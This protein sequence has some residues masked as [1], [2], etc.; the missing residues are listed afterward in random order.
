MP[1]NSGTIYQIRWKEICPWLI[2]TSAWR[3]SFFLTVLFLSWLGV[4]L[5]QWGW[6]SLDGVLPLD[7][8][9]RPSAELLHSQRLLAFSLYAHSGTESGPAE[10]LVVDGGPFLNAWHWLSLPFLRMFSSDC[11]WGEVAKLLLVGLWGITVWSF[12][13]G[14]IA[15]IA[16]LHLCRRES[17]PISQA[18][19]SGLKNWTATMGAPCLGLAFA[20]LICFPLGIIG[21]VM[22]AAGLLSLLGGVVWFLWIAWGAV[23]AIVLVALWFGWPFAWATTAVEHSDAFDAVSRAAAYVY[24]RPLHLAFYIVVASLLGIF[25]QLV[26]DVFAHAI[27]VATDWAISWGA[28][29]DWTAQL[30]STTAMQEGPETHS[31]SV[32]LAV[33]AIQFWRSALRSLA[34]AYPLGYLFTSSVGIY[35]LMRQHID[36]T[37]LDEIAFDDEE[38][39]EHQGPSTPSSVAG[40]EPG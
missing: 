6:S 5:T 1:A 16:A 7:E 21:L 34:G 24:Q 19:H 30:T 25:G 31:G 33:D 4:L 40:D 28:G 3:A 12:V 20:A 39:I 26:V 13:G 27:N 32:A 14:M 9:R 10:M 8:S 35:L 36:G 22:R 29:N 2:L 37:E 11:S 15:R 38:T 17:L 23:L 18:V